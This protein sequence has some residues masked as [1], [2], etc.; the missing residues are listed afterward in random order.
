[1]LPEGAKG[2]AL[3]EEFDYKEKGSASQCQMAGEEG[4]KRG[5]FTTSSTASHSPAVPCAFGESIVAISLSFRKEM[6]KEK[7]P[8]GIR[9]LGA[10]SWFVLCRAA[11]NERQNRH[12]VRVRRSE[13]LYFQLFSPQKNHG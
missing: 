5:F 4:S 12:S 1:M 10:F 11:K 2:H 3:R 6:A 7:E 8:R 9:P 13:Q